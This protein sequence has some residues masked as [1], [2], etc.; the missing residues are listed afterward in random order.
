MTHDIRKSGIPVLAYLECDAASPV[1]LSLIFRFNEARA[2]AS[3]LLQ[4]S[5]FVDGYDDKQAFVLQYDAD[6]L[7]PGKSAL[8]PATILLPQ[9][10]LN[11][12][13][14]EG[15]PQIRTLSLTLKDLCSVWCQPS[16]ETLKSKPGSGDD[17]V[18]HQF[19]NLSKAT[20]LHILFD[21]N[22][23]HRDHHA[24]F[25]RLITRPEQL[26]GFPVWRHYSKQYRRGDWSIFGARD[27]EHVD[28][29]AT[30]EDEKA[31]PPAYSEG[32]KR[33]RHGEP[34]DCIDAPLTANLQLVV[35][36]TTPS[37]PPAKRILLSPYSVDVHTSPTEKGSIATPS[38]KSLHHSG[39]AS[40]NFPPLAALSPGPPLYI[41]EASPAHTQAL[42]APSPQLSCVA[43]PDIQLAV[44]KTVESL[45]PN[46]LDKLM[47]SLLPRLLYTSTP[48]TSQ[49]SIASQ[50]S[51]APSPP[52]TLSALGVSLGD[53]M[54]SRIEEELSRLY[55]Q[56]LS[57]ANYLRNSADAEF[58][59][60]RELERLAF[61]RM[62]E[63]K[64]E[65]FKG[66]CEGLGEAELAHVEEKMDEL[67][68]RLTERVDRLREERE[69]LEREKEE[70]RKDREEVRRDK[71]DLRRDKREL[72]RDK[73]SLRK[74]KRDLQRERER[75]VFRC[76]R[77]EDETSGHDAQ[78]TRA[79]TAPL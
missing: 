30:T 75:E 16:L 29:D 53:H 42:Q 3:L 79:G 67:G 28:T 39:G 22:W 64:F 2:T 10:R 17:I 15:N 8:G 70:L 18:F 6:N 25:H 69:R 24:I 68:E 62:A 12:V 49:H 20:Q 33:P 50:L 76:R 36:P 60:E 38:P 1:S 13:A 4:S 21:Y 65:E 19:A 34:S 63:T 52:T 51:T 14:R 40:P 78:R 56:T 74:Q 57:H 26:T 27:S 37:S 43:A 41:A 48:S 45:L 73:K 23:L 11:E 71:E 35:T 61:D 77:S 9:Y 59:E 72:R 44:Q 54:T 31:P 32:S 7:K 66:Q 58:F 55:A 5:L 47:P 46:L